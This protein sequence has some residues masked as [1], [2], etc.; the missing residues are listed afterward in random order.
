[1]S[2]NASIVFLI[3]S[4][5]R[6]MQDIR[7]TGI[8]AFATFLTLPSFFRSIFRIYLR[9]R[10]ENPLQ[11]SQ[12]NLDDFLRDIEEQ[13]N[14]HLTTQSL[15]NISKSLQ[16][17]FKEQLQKCSG[18]MLPSFNHTLPTGNES[19][20]Y[21]SLDVGGSTLRV[22]LVELFGRKSVKSNGDMPMRIIRMRSW[23]ID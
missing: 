11:S 12:C 5:Y 3:L 15:L 7:R 1:M 22:A 9:T 17:Q 14:S 2:S 16:A 6:V 8:I 23:K 10:C 19:G 4:L 20:R 13:F 21:L 18:C